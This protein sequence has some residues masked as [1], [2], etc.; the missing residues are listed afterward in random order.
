MSEGLGKIGKIKG[1]GYI[2]LAL[3]VGVMLLIF[4]GGEEK[5]PVKD[6]VESYTESVEKRLCSLAES[7]CGVECRVALNIESGYKYSYACDQTV[8][9]SYNPDG[10]VASRETVLT[11]RTVNT[12]GGTA[13][14]PVKTSTPKVCGVAIVCDGASLADVSRLKTLVAALYSLDESAIFVTD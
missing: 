12:D 9:V 10:S 2:V 4:N 13:L 8:T 7:L 1:I 11:N 5:E 6:S 14:V 3:A